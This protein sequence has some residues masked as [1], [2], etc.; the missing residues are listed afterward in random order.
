MKGIGFSVDA[1]VKIGGESVNNRAGWEWQVMSA[2]EILFLPPDDS[3]LLTEE[4][5]VQ[6]V[7][8]GD[9]RSNEYLYRP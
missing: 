7:N 9:I 5:A 4:T 2:N 3:A 8:P 6:V 1:D